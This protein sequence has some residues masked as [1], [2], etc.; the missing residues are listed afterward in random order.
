[1]K[2]N[3]SKLLVGLAAAA[4]ISYALINSDQ[5]LNPSDPETQAKNDKIKD[6]KAKRGEQLAKYNDLMSI[7]EP[8]KAATAVRFCA[9]ILEDSEMLAMVHKAELDDRIRTA[10]DKNSSLLDRLI[11][12]QQIEELDPR[13]GD[14]LKSLKAQLTKLNEAQQAETVREMLKEK[15]RRGV[16]IGM[17]KEDVLASSW[18]RPQSVNQSTYTFGVREQWVYGGGN[19]L[20][21]KDGVLDSI[22]TS[23]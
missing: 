22:Q 19:Y 11:A 10:S 21:F 5:Q 9:K 12:I 16:S 8:W 4:L 23:N 7:G 18:G 17:T 20:Y 1:M 15:K 14:E 3:I 13:K 6:C 2:K